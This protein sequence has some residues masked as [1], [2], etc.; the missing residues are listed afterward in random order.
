MTSDLD[1][2]HTALVLNR[3]HKDERTGS[4]IFVFCWT[5]CFGLSDCS[6]GSK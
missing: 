4:R 2:Y 6:K 5:P 3:E 1:I